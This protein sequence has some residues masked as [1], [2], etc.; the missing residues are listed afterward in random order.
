M[1]GM[2]ALLVA[3]LLVGSTGSIRC[4]ATCAELT[5]FQS[6]AHAHQAAVAMPDH[7][8]CHGRGMDSPGP[9]S[10]SSGESCERGCCT[11][12]THATVTPNPIPGPVTG[13]SPLRAGVHLDDVRTHADLLRESPPLAR[14]ASPFRFRNPP[15]LI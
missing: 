13:V 12:L 11:V 5:A 14:L 15:L 1:L 8:G 6:A 9:L 7:G 4:Q 3:V 2:R 10:E